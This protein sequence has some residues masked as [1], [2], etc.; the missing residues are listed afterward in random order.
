[1]SDLAVLRAQLHAYRDFDECIVLDLRWLDWGTSLVLD[2]DFVWRDDG[3]VRSQEE[4]RR[5]VSIR[6][7]GVSEV[8]VVNDLTDAQL[9]EEQSL[10]W[11]VGEIACLRVERASALARSRP[12]IPAYRAALRREGYTWIDV[13]FTRW[14]FSESVQSA[15]QSP[16]NRE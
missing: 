10:G 1:M 6:F 11:S 5:V 15:D 4:N 14:E 13:S 3:T 8:H 7:F 9:G 2:L 16:L 12:S